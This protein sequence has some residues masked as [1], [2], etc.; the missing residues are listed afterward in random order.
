[1]RFISLAALAALTVLPGAAQAETFSTP[2]ALFQ[3]LYAP[4][5]ADEWSFDYQP[6]LSASLRALYDEDRA[7][8]AEGEIGAIDF[9]PIIAGQDFDISDLRIGTPDI[10]GNEAEVVV[11]FNNMGERITLD[12]D[13]VREKGSWLVD[14]IENETPGYEWDL[15]DVFERNGVGAD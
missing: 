13:L 3:A 4:Y 8:T 14:N 6:Y 5:I 15:R 7:R 2:E 11:T 9:D 1:M 10:D 12:Y